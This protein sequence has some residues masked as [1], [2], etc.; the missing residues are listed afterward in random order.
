MI[1]IWQPR[2]KDNAVLIATY[3]VVNGDNE[4]VFTKA[5]HLLGMKF[6][7]SSDVIRNCPIE[8]NGKISCYAVPMEELKRIE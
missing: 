5:K 6:V 8:S 3:K 4:I 7:C 1:A 2:Y